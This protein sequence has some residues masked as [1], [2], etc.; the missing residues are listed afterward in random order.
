MI[1]GPAAERYSQVE[2]LILSRHTLIVQ[3]FTLFSKLIK[4][5]QAITH[6][7]R[8]HSTLL[9]LTYKA[10]IRGKQTLGLELYTYSPVGQCIY[11]NMNEKN[12]NIP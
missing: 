11:L 4:K 1:L 8:Q 7:R 5:P 2:L 3:V 12:I 9:Q 6:I 10:I